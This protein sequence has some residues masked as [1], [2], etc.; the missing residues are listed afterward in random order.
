MRVLQEELFMRLRAPAPAASRMVCSAAQKA[1]RSACTSAPRRAEGHSHRFSGGSAAFARLMRPRSL[2]HR[3]STAAFCAAA[4]HALALLTSAFL[5]LNGA[6]RRVGKQA[7]PKAPCKGACECS[8]RSVGAQAGSSCDKMWAAPVRS[9]EALSG[10]SLHGRRYPVG[11]DHSA[12]LIE[13]SISGA[14]L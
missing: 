7:S 11:A 4:R 2:Q 3:A 9:R 14:R 6:G 8:R 1:A 5:L 13:R 10:M 12:P